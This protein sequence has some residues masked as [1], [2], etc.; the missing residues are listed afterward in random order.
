M[1]RK[2]G[3][4]ASSKAE[5]DD[6]PSVSGPGLREALVAWVDKATGDGS[7]EGPVLNGAVPV[8]ERQDLG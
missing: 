5:V 7:R 4:T 8:A 3:Q 2:D 6:A 1:A